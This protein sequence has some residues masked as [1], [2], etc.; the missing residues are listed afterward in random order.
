MRKKYLEALCELFPGYTHGPILIKLVE[1]IY[2]PQV[3]LLNVVLQSDLIKLKPVY[4]YHQHHHST[5][6]G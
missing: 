4:T 6:L 2:H 3:L 1:E 5:E